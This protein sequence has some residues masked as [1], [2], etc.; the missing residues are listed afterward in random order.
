MNRL[1]WTAEEIKYLRKNYGIIST[2]KMS[3]E[4]DRS[5][6]SISK[7]CYDLGIASK[8]PYE[9]AKTIKRHKAVYSNEQHEDLVERILTTY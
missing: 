5:I 3:E 8:D 6:S 7:K 4:L 1:T 9:P 2:D